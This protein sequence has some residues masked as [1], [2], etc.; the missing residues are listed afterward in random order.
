MTYGA[1][2]A[3]SASVQRSD[4]GLRS[5]LIPRLTQC[6][7]ALLSKARTSRRFLSQTMC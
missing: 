3:A 5:G 2:G 1:N 6:P 4:E 7:P